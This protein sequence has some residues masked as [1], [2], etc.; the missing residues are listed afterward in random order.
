M[1]VVGGVI[2]SGIFRKAGVMAGEVGSPTLLLAVW[3]I[4]GTITLF[5]ALTN[6][7]VAGMIPETGGQYVYFD[8]MFGPF[9][10]YLYGWAVFA[11]IQTG[12]IAAVAYVFAEYSTQF[13]KLPEFNSSIAA[14]GFHVPFIGD[15]L[16]LKDIGTKGVAAILVIGL[17]A[18]NYVGV[19]F[20]GLVQNIFTIAKVIAMALLFL[21]AFLLPTGGSI[22]NLTN[23]SSVIHPTGLALF[24]ALAAAMQGA[25][26]AYDG[27]NKLTYIAGEIKEPQRNVP[28]GL[29]IGMLIVTGIYMLINLAYS[30]VLPVDVMAGSKLV[31]A[32]VAEKCFKGGGRWIA[33]AVMV[34]TFGTTNSII[35]ASA[36]V[37]FSMSRR[38]VFPQL[39][40]VA[41]PKFHTP[42]AS[43]V[44][45]G[46]WSV[47][48][49]FSGTFDTLT[50]TLIF[51]SWIFYALS[52]YGVFVLRRKEPG[53]PRPYRVPGYPFIPWIFIAFSALYLVLTVYNDLVGY[54][55]AV[56]AGKPAIINSAFGVALVLVGTPIYWFYRRKSYSS[57]SG[58]P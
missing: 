1:M 32:D 51:V 50:D 39:L 49:L 3:L 26:W 35:L 48:L 9:V 12:S 40:G 6:S 28:R 46:I 20:G 36:R 38:N 23:S 54:R 22:S 15:V 24:L 27:W 30:Y 57:K 53:T 16:P 55:E 45:Q 41:H 4:A 43:L 31:A 44:V 42:A 5:G 19:K 33:A 21:G 2:G 56:A 14:L 13:I 10:A 34:S 58:P 47:L 29:I 18:V 37:Y 8:R 52:A 17:T 11:V 7:E 25:F